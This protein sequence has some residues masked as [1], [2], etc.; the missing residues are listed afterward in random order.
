MPSDEEKGS[1]AEEL[2]GF[3]EV[4]SFQAED[5]EHSSSIYR[6]YERLAARNLLYL[7]AELRELEL[8]LEEFDRDD[9]Q[10]DVEDMLAAMN[11]QDASDSPTE[12]H[13]P[14]VKEARRKQLILR[15]RAK[16]QEYRQF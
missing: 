14:N 10:G 2:V 13:Y 1:S 16:I 3:A 11:W 7:Q 4:A 5:K 12:D 8:E 15:L 9:A 6:R